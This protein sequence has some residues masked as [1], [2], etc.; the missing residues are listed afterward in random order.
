[1]RRV[2]T[3]SDLRGKK[4]YSL[5]AC[6]RKALPQQKQSEWTGRF[7]PVPIGTFGVFSGPELPTSSKNRSLRNMSTL[8]NDLMNLTSSVSQREIRG[9]LKAKPRNIPQFRRSADHPHKHCNFRRAE[10]QRAE[11]AG[12]IAQHFVQVRWSLAKSYTCTRIDPK[13]LEILKSSLLAYKS[14]APYG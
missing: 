5:F 9:S 4:Q 8:P 7:T 14:K 10:L 6:W 12:E 2:Q 3:P 1:M 11:G 13:T